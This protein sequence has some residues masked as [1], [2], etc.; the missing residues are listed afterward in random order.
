MNERWD[1]RVVRDNPH[2]RSWTADA[3][4]LIFTKRAI[5]SQVRDGRGYTPYHAREI[6]VLYGVDP[7]Y[8]AMTA[9]ERGSVRKTVNQRPGM[10]MPRYA[11][12]GAPEVFAQIRP[13]K[14]KELDPN[15]DL[16]AYGIREDPGVFTGT[17]M[18]THLQEYR[19]RHTR[20]GAYVVGERPRTAYRPFRQPQAWL[21]EH[22]T[23]E[24]DERG[25]G[26]A[27]FGG[28][29]MVPGS[30]VHSHSIS[31]AKHE[32]NPEYAVD[33]QQSGGGEEVH[34]HHEYAKYL[35][36]SGG[37]VVDERAERPAK[38]VDVHPM[39]LPLIETGGR[40]CFFVLEGLLKNDAI[41]TQ[42]E[43]VLNCGSVTLWDD[44]A[45]GEFAT[46]F[47]RRFETV[48]IVPDSD[49]LGNENVA[50]QA[51]RLQERFGELWISAIVAAPAATCSEHT[52]N[53]ACI[54]PHR[55]SDVSGRSSPEHKNGVDDWLGSGRSLDEMTAWE[56][57]E[58]SELLPAI[59][60][61][62]RSK[63]RNQR[64]LE[65]LCT[66]QNP[67]SGR[68]RRSLREIGR[69]LRMDKNRVWRA[70]QDLDEAGV[71]KRIP[72]DDLYFG[73]DSTTTVQLN[74]E[75]RTAVPRMLSDV[76]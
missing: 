45:L 76:T 50:T 7:K 27:D 62:L 40:R 51:R 23:W 4:E 20:N 8:E 22:I 54:H 65:Y 74:D 6:G 28:F 58:A 67:W 33:H 5:S 46:E 19:H 47:L 75:L 57:P 13:F 41:L 38:V 53:P 66:G 30:E 16:S 11:I 15:L 21:I 64:V 73:Y 61:Q 52:G 29:D 37:K 49:W 14:F 56:D 36:V 26:Y 3:F 12:P 2:L 60:L 48:V 43:P 71:I 70:M 31:W 35:F 55:A 10:V 34:K 72:P 59:G 69:S 44:P 25:W 24:H 9:G 39:G 17:W 18:H 42:G 32:A 68:V 1:L 63:E